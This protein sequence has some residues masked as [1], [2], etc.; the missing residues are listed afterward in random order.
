MDDGEL[1]KVP[2][3]NLSRGYQLDRLTSGDRSDRHAWNS[4]RRNKEADPAEVVA[5][6]VVRVKSSRLRRG[7]FA[8]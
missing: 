1:E 7:W 3:R 8:I 2:R 4:L 6:A 5:A